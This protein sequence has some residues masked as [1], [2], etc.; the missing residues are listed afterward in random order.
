MPRV[1]VVLGLLYPTHVTVWRA[2]RELGVDVH[3]AGALDGPLVEPHQ[4]APRRFRDIP[5]HPLEVRGPSFLVE[6]GLQWWWLDG[7]SR[8]VRT[9]RPDVV[10]VVSEVWGLMAVQALSSGLPTVI[11]SWDNLY[12]HGRPLEDLIR[13]TI[14][15]RNL[16]RVAGHACANRRGLQLARDNGLPQEVPAI[17]GPP[18][19]PAPEEFKP[20]D[21]QTGPIPTV[22]FVGRLV[23]EKG[24][25]WLLRAFDQIP[26]DARLLVCGDGPLRPELERR[27]VDDPR[28]E[29]RGPVP[30]SEMPDVITCMDVLVIPSRSRPDWEEQ[31]GRVAVEAMMAGVP[32]IVSSSGALP[33][34]AGPAG[35]VVPEGDV[36]ALAEAIRRL[37][38]SPDERRLRRRAGVAW[39]ESEHVPDVVAARVMGLWTD[40]LASS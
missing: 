40:V 22:G 9:V 26:V 34:V 23:A 4:P 31:Y 21:T 27:S 2:A 13:L 14:A 39:T 20:R 8:T 1:L 28:V 36:D 37:L 15:R 17:V 7:L 25:G 16:R 6:R 11:H 38:A 19:I 5:T 33:E 3:V 24:I 10:H 29:F 12:R 32:V 35:V 30:A 18:V